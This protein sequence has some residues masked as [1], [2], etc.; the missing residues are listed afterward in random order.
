MEASKEVVVGREKLSFIKG[1]WYKSWLKE[2]G[3]GNKAQVEGSP[4]IH[5]NKKEVR[6]YGTDTS[7]LANVAKVGWGNF[8]LLSFQF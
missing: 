5:C 4:F 6:I 2:K 7:S 8:H 1:Q 3:L